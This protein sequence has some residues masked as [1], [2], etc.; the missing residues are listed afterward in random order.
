[1]EVEAGIS[2][3]KTPN[4]KTGGGGLRGGEAELKRTVEYVATTDTY[5]EMSKLHVHGQNARIFKSDDL[6]ALLHVP[7]SP[8]SRYSEH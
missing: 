8:T 6:P 4:A 2:S 5:A 7:M 3:E 1:M